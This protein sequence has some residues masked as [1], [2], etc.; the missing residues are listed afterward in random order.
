MS[1]DPQAEGELNEWVHLSDWD[2]AWP[3]RARVLM[4]E[5]A[6][7][8]GRDAHIEHIGSTA[9]EGMVAKPILDLMLGARGEAEQDAFAHP[10]Q[11]A[12]WEDLGE[13]GIAGRRH[14]R[15][16]SGEAANL[17]VVI[18]GGRHWI[19][20]I[21]IRDFL[22]SNPEER[23]AYASLKQASLAGGADR[24]L[25]YSARKADFVAALLERALKWRR[26]GDFGR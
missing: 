22:R 14:L 10:L 13:A 7:S 24:L 4:Q 8:V 25:A 1:S 2:P 9:V 12:G 21:A 26:D 3:R 5:V 11:R 17:H 23:A 15:R 6:S 19:N 16:R 20:N 18:L